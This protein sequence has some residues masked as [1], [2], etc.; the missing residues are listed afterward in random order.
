MQ[1]NAAMAETQRG[2]IALPLVMLVFLAMVLG[3][4]YASRNLL[5][6]H[7]ASAN[8]YRSTQAFEAAEAGL[9]WTIAQLSKNAAVGA[10]CLPTAAPAATSFRQRYLRLDPSSGIVSPTTWLRNGASAPLQP[11]CVRDGETWNCA[12]PDAGDPV[13]GAP[14]GPAIAPA[15]SVLLEDVGRA[16]LLRVVSNGCTRLGGNCAGGTPPADATARVEVLV[17]L[18]PA[19]RTPPVAALTVRGLVDADGAAFGAH[20]ADPQSGGIAI[21]AGGSVRAALAH[22][23]GPAGGAEPGR[24][25]AGDASLANLTAA[26]FFVSYFGLDKVTWSAQP[27]VDPVSCSGNCVASVLARIDSSR[28]FSI[29]HIDGDLL[30]EGPAT[31]GSADRPLLIVASGQVTLRG[32]VAL[33][34]VLY[35]ASVEW[36]GGAT[37]GASV[38]GALISEG[39]FRSDA[40]PEIRYSAQVLERFRTRAGTYAR[41]AGSWKDF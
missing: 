30:L 24:V 4:G 8:Q 13:L 21:L 7:R 6:E 3:I 31:L 29:V 41:V 9:E 12:C 40:S 39:D 36:V 10:D 32:A 1:H 18:L 38:E 14:G 17:G 33:T 37:A 35:G 15:H 19:L 5:F 26:R 16:G 23:T 34:G 28:E 27:I 11:A 22:L 25:V 20:N 2:V